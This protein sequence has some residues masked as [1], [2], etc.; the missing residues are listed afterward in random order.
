MTRSR[1]QK[2]QL[3][4]LQN[5]TPELARR[6]KKVGI[7]AKKDFWAEDPY[8]IFHLLR[9]NVT[10][11]LG[12]ETLASIV[13]AA[14]NRPWQEVADEAAAEYEQRYPQHKF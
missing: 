6:L 10:S 13:G 5:I 2:A 4:T 8:I 12:K 14:R 1:S 9:K 11:S 3:T 7:L